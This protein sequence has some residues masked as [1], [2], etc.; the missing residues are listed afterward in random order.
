MNTDLITKGE[1]RQIRNVTP[2]DDYKLLLEFKS[3]E[4]RIFDMKPLLDK[5]VFQ[6]LKNKQLFSKV[7]VIFDYT[8]AWSD[9]IDM[10]PDS[11]YM[12]SVPLD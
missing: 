7:H 5:P 10:C 2:L 11:L 12:Q 9:D 8:I 3:G 4:K 1:V 6:P